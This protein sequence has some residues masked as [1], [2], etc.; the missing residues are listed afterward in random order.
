MAAV[1]RARLLDLMK[2][3]MFPAKMKYATWANLPTTAPMPN[4]FDDI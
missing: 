1:S 4:I 2:V 3:Q